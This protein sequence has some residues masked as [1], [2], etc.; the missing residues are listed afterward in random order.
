MALIS[1]KLDLD[2]KTFQAALQR[3]AKALA[4]LDDRPGNFVPSFDV[5]NLPGALR[6]ISTLQGALG[7]L[8]SMGAPGQFGMCQ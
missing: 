1:I 4:Q 2:D 7:A 3:T 5:S 8:G 6:Q